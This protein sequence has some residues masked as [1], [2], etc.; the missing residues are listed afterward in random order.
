MGADRL[1]EATMATALET[2]IFR[3]EGP[4]QAPTSPPP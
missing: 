3:G 1:I 2:G 4:V